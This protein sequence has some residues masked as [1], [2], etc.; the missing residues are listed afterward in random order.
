MSEPVPGAADNAGGGDPQPAV[1][2]EYVYPDGRK[3]TLANFLRRIFF[4]PL[5]FGLIIATMGLAAWGVLRV[6]SNPSEAS[7][8]T[9]FL[10]MATAILPTTW[11]ILS[12]LWKESADVA[13]MVALAR[14]II[15]PLVVAWPPAIVVAIMVHI[16]AVQQLMADN[17]RDDGWRYY[18]SGD[19]MSLL[20]QSLVITGLGGMLFAIL[21]G[22]VLSVF[23][24]LPILA[25]FKPLAAARSNML[26][27]DTPEERV[28]AKAGIRML[29]VILIM[30]FGVPALIFVGRNEATANS[31]LEAFAN[32]PMFFAEPQYYYGDIM[33]ALGILA[34][35]FGVYI[36]FKLKKVQRADIARRAQF[37]VN[38][39]EDHEAWLESQQMGSGPEGRL[40][41][42]EPSN[43]PN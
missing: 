20:G 1:T 34:I 35:P 28:A 39:S 6:A 4:D 31:W 17:T 41:K 42:D 12:V 21:T 19:E 9:G 18:F 32:V 22:L 15:V 30:T 23:V 5:T 40:P 8:L 38:S 16:P 27:T 14:T 36:V 37:G 13:V 3:D 43:G 11:S 2:A 7:F 25:W 26:L 10:I 29:S 24:V 33:W